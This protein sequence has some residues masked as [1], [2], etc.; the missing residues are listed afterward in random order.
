M[1]EIITST[2]V[3]V[4]SHSTQHLSK[5]YKKSKL[6]IFIAL[7]FL[8]SGCSSTMMNPD[9]AIQVS[10]VQVNSSFLNLDKVVVIEKQ[11]RAKTNE[12]KNSGEFV[13]LNRLANNQQ[14]L[15][16]EI[17]LS[18]QFGSQKQFQLSVNELPLNDFLHY[19]LGDLL[20][21][22]YLI[23]PSVKANVSPVTLE[24]KEK[25][26][27]QRLFQL[28]QQILNQHK[29]NIALNEQVF[30]VHPLASSGN[31]T[32]MA[33]GFGRKESDVPRVSS[34]IIQLVPLKYGTSTHLRN[35]IASL[36][37][38]S[39]AID[40]AQGLLT[41]RG[42]REQVLRAL[43]LVNLLDSAGIHNKAIGL[44]SFNYI[45]SLTFIDKVTE[46]L[47]QEGIV[48]SSS[49]TNSSSIKFVPIEHLGKVVVFASADE[50]LDRVEYWAK[51]LDKP[52]T[53]SEQS[54]YTYHPRYARAS[55]LGASLAP[56]LGGSNS[57]NGNRSQNSTR[58]NVSRATNNN[59][60]R[61][62]STQRNNGNSV[63][64]IEG[65][66][67]RMVVDERSNALIF[68]S[69]G[70][71]YQGLLPIIKKLDVMPKQVMLEVIIAEVK[72]TGSFSKGVQFALKSGDSGNNKKSISYNG[73]DGFAYS[74]VGLSGNFNISL[75]QK[76]GL[77]NVL[78][79]PTL[80]VRDGVS[81]SISVGD[82]IPT[83][84]STTSDPINGERQTTTI[85]YRKTGIDLTVTPTINAQ[86]TVIMTI[87]LNI[88]NVSPDGV[89]ISGTPSIFERKLSTEVVAG[90]GQ[91][92]LLGGLISENK[93]SNANAIPILGSLPIIGHLFR[94]DADSSDKTELV[95]L[96]TPRII[97]NVSE[98]NRI[99][100]SFIDGLENIQL[101][102]K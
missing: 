71:F 50:I 83:V 95:I 42:R 97:H 21:V 24:L 92:V 33:F 58:S 59:Q 23:E 40:P 41:I 66:N 39:V 27:A 94:S 74:I 63:Q 37:D 29:V 93:S 30:Y 28:V 18:K 43:S 68:Y 9:K 4:Q 44:V 62:Q 48:A 88:S 67:I 100:Q 14:S 25:V 49:R 98:W 26:S 12:E 34:N 79:R 84:G 19:V 6:A 2:A 65:D 87:E 22:S 96:V 61:Q 38:A 51:Q 85:Q 16:L 13:R 10:K 53:G 76:D 70:K 57:F 47:A 80:L 82:D 32:N 31:K 46:L 102:L 52:A 81:A 101:E 20:Q 45:D 64:T 75:N 17:D 86:G 89:D 91:T 54:F 56:L 15:K 72:L 90:D 73:K 11:E 8:V 7:T 1:N 55:D 36:V 5:S 99:Q 78:S 35:T 3:S 60:N 77:I 69:T